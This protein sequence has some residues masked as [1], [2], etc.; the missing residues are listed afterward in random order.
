[1]IRDKELLGSITS[2]RDTKKD[3]NPIATVRYD[4]DGKSDKNKKNKF[5]ED[6]SCALEITSGRDRVYKVKANKIGELFNP[7][8]IGMIYNLQML[9]RITNNP[10]FRFKE[11][12]ENGFGAYI[13]FLQTKKENLLSVAEREVRHGS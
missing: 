10:S 7:L 4:T 11:I 5:T 6:G 12:S 1:M 13:A 3:I 2:I 8:K 9:D